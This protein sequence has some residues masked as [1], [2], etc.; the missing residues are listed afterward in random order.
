[1]AG[2]CC[3]QCD[4]DAD[5]KAGKLMRL[6]VRMNFVCTQCGGRECPHAADH[7]QSCEKPWMAK[8]S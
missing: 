6:F 3:R 5:P 4:K 7:R 8:A 2:Y 1:M